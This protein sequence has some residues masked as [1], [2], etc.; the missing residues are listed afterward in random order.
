[1]LLVFRDSKSDGQRDLAR[2]FESRLLRQIVLFFQAFAALH[3]SPLDALLNIQERIIKG[4]ATGNVV[5]LLGRHLS[6]GQ[7]KI[8]FS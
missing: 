7:L 6:L 5:A 4:V 2:G 8:L 3:F 1:M